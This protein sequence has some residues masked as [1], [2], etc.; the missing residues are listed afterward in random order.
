MNVRTATPDD[1]D[2][3]AALHRAAVRAVPAEE[4]DECHLDAWDHERSPDDYPLD[5]PDRT[6]LVAER[7][8]RVDGTGR[9]G[10]VAGF[11]RASHDRGEVEACYV[12][13]DHAGRE[14]GSALL[15]GLEG[16]LAARG[17]ATVR[18]VAS[19]NA[20]GFYEAAGYDRVEA[21]T[22]E[23]YRGVEFPCVAM[24]K[25]LP[26]SAGPGPVEWGRLPA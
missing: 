18:T 8:G 7:S 26:S 3:V 14:V 2:R 12:H 17:T 13:P 22:L 5:D 6:L 1:L 20:V 4:Y 19:L 11:G 23:G 9:S 10:R 16:R 25:S 15:A 21:V 24:E